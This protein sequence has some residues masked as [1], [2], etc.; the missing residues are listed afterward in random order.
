M[1]RYEVD[2]AQ[3]AQAAAAVQARTAAVR[4]EVAALQRQLNE[5]SPDHMSELQQRLA[6]VRTAIRE[7]A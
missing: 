2:S 1:S 3:V 6:E 5:A 7:F 4:A